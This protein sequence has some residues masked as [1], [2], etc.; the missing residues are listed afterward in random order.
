MRF[1]VPPGA[2]ADEVPDW[3]ALAVELIAD[4]DH[5]T[6]PGSH[7]ASVSLKE[8]EISDAPA[9][10]ESFAAH[11]M[12]NFDRWAHE[13][14]AP[15]ASRYSERLLSG[16]ALDAKGDLLLDDGIKPLSEALSTAL[17]RDEKGPIL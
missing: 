4:R 2:S 1:A 13:G 16:G 15:V 10:L 3:I 7:P 5:L 17:W 9:V 12:L 11:L 8:E 6:S 14:F